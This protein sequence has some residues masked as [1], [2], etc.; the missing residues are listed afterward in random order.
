MDERA[1]EGL[2]ETHR[3]FARHAIPVLETDAR[4][5][6]LA[7]AG[8]WATGGM[9]AF[10]D[11]D[12]TVVVADDALPGV[13][14]EAPAIAASL[15]DLLV[16]FTGEHVGA[17]SLLICLYAPWTLH[18]DLKFAALDELRE[19]IE[20]PIVLF[21]RAGVLEPLIRRTRPRSLAPDPQWLE[22]RFWVWI[23]YAAAKIAR[24]ELL[25]TLDMLAFL[26]AQ[27]L[28][29]LVAL[30]HGHAPRGVRRVEEY[31]RAELPALLR[32]AAAPAPEACVEALRSALE[33]YVELRDADTERRPLLR[34][35]RARAA[36]I[37]FLDAVAQ[38]L[39][40][41]R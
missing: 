14:R 29:P 9:D 39:P 12:F 5:L 40:L 30:R 41:R 3:A 31:A 24:G 23:H 2:P 18:V 1:L 16:A 4:V 6:A 15:G 33:L 20:N 38:A 21:D 36:A 10:S 37:G 35:D 27:V 17:P 22:D 25:E 34:R 7:A 11:L 28:G 8:S 13:L 19:R 32:T 26:R